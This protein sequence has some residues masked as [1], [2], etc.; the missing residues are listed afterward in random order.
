MSTL[1]FFFAKKVY[2][3]AM[4]N[5]EKAAKALRETEKG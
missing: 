1:I 4:I 3:T 2:R 5:N